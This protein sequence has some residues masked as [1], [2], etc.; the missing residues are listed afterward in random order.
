MGTARLAGVYKTISHMTI[1]KK[2]DASGDGLAAWCFRC[3]SK[4]RPTVY[5]RPWHGP[6][7]YIPQSRNRGYGES[8]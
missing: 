8:L 5:W 6:F 4:R 2:S 7:T 3:K 1:K